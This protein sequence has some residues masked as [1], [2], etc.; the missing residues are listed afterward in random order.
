MIFQTGDRVVFLGAVIAE[1]VAWA[2]TDYPHLD[3]GATYT[4][5]TSKQFPSFTHVTL[6]GVEGKF[7]SVHFRV[8]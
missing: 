3:V 7:N 1:Q 5:A 2:G 6:D 8:V 4:V